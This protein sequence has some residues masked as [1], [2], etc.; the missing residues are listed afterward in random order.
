MKDKEKIL[1]IMHVDWGWIKQRPHFLAEGLNKF[2]DLLVMYRFNPI[3]KHMIKND[4]DV[5][6]LPLLTIPRRFGRF[7]EKMDDFIQII[8][9]TMVSLVFKPQKIWLTFPSQYKYIP[10]KLLKKVE[11]IYDCMDD[12]KE[13][14]DDP[15]R[16][17][18]I[19]FLEKELIK[20][21]RTILC[22]SRH[23]GDVLENRYGKLDNLCLVRNG[24]KEEFISS[25]SMAE[26]VKSIFQ[27]NEGIKDVVY[28]GTIANW[29]NFQM[30]DKCLDENKNVRFHFIGPV[31]YQPQLVN[32]DK[33][34]FH[35]PIEHSRLIENKELYDVLIMPFIRNELIE[36]VDPVKLYEYIAFE[37]PIISVYYPE[38]ERFNDYV[39]FYKNQQEFF[40]L[41]KKINFND[42]ETKFEKE[43]GHAFLENNTWSKR[44]ESIV[45][46]I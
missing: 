21:A 9:I 12:C 34:I 29:I 35:G 24:L 11:L 2:Y 5:K 40:E 7:F 45:E 10:K 1:Y 20:N 38:I 39:Y 46:K 3:R 13:F 23:L 37:K 25:R 19:E 33:V 15:K 6:K 36:S 26:N 32:S 8:W 43:L 31:D 44:V 16:K 17:K 28:I 18:D 42:L 30:I 27:K 4:S 22:S 14:Y 41:I